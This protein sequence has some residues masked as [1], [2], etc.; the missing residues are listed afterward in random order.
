MAYKTATYTVAW[1]DDSREFFHK[2]VAS[3]T[4]QFPGVQ[5]HALYQ[6]VHGPAMAFH[7]SYSMSH[8][9]AKTGDVV[10]VTVSFHH[11]PTAF[12]S[13]VTSFSL[14]EWKPAPAAPPPP[15]PAPPV[16]W[17]ITIY[18]KIAGGPFGGLK[19]KLRLPSGTEKWFTTDSKGVIYL[20]EPD[21]TAGRVDVMD[22]LDDSAT[23]SIS[24]KSYSRTGLA[25]GGKH[26]L[27]IPNERKAIDL[28][29]STAGVHRRSSY[30]KK[31]PPYSKMD[32]DWDYDTVV[33]HHSG[34]GGEN[35]PAEIE[36]QHMG[37]KGYD[38]IGYH[39]M[40]DLKGK[41]FEGRHLAYKGSH[42]QAAN[43]AKIGVLMMGDFEH[44]WW[45]SD[46]DPTVAQTAS[47]GK[48]VGALKAILPTLAKL[49]GHRDYKPSTECPGGEMYKLIPALRSGTGLGG[50]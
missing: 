23:P 8:P 48:L 21:I 49:G 15:P 29:I 10:K 13:T 46:D 36:S 25:T 11:D 24:Y 50:P 6:P 37:S 32:Q 44:Q 14:V 40:I 20:K 4:K 12:A 43:T 9:R 19:M 41:I 28:V 27:S 17:Q 3:V 38:D 1:H 39:F 31:T 22:A 30:G 47:L 42:V 2:V 26:T 45:D 16:E 33:I 35:N 18:D 34:N 7:R 5:A